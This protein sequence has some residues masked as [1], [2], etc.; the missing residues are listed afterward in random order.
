MTIQTF[1]SISHFKTIEN[2]LVL[3]L[4][5][6]LPSR[7]L[8]AR[9]V[10]LRHFAESSFTSAADIGIKKKPHS[11]LKTSWKKNITIHHEC[12]CR[13]EI[14]HLRGRNFNQG[15][16]LLS[17]WLYSDAKGAISLSYV[18]RLMIDCFSPNF[19][20]FFVGT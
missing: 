15:R 11:S 1:S 17:P 3:S 14:S 9:A 16:G 12:P 13:V 19:T 20:R 2:R 4:L 10:N 5:S 8:I 6:I 7:D 18:D